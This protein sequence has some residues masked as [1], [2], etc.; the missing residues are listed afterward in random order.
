[1]QAVILAAGRGSRLGTRSDETPKCLLEVG[2]RRLIEHQL[3]MLSEAG[4]GPVA[5]VLGYCAAEIREVVGIQAEYIENPSWDTTNSLYS[6][7]LAREWVKGPVLVL[8]SDLL[9]HPEILARVVESEGDCIAY[10]S[11]SGH[12]GEHMKVRVVDGRLE[13]M[14][15]TLAAEEVSGE[16]IGVLRF[17]EDTARR[18]FEMAES[19]IEDGGATSWLGSA[20]RVLAKERV[21]H[22]VDAAGL[23]WGE[24]DFSFDL[25]RV[26]REVW[27]A[28]RRDTARSPA[29]RGLRR[30][31]SAVVVVLLLAVLAVSSWTRPAESTWDVVFLDRDERVEIRSGEQSR[32]WSRLNRSKGAEFSVA[33]P[34][35]LRVD[36]RLLLDADVES[37]LYVLEVLMDGERVD[38]FKVEGRKSGS[39]THE[40]WTVS[41]RRR[42]DVEIPEGH[43]LVRVRLVAAESGSCLLRITRKDAAIAA[44]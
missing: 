27:P 13:E 29:F 7:W 35:E 30:A 40:E 43:H 3:E 4:V 37:A 42:I 36:S 11:G 1:M 6:F 32:K 28:I 2:R 14:S 17:E 15:K 44:D 41:K 5:M 19:I 10:D 16:N 26:R 22:A 24:I 39:W 25:V 21:I 9:L 18:L 31:A 23:P 20:V 34:T 8:N 38:W 33:G 12:G